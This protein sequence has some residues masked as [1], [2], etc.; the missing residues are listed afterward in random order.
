VESRLL[1]GR[2][3]GSGRQPG[4]LREPSFHVRCRRDDCTSIHDEASS[5]FCRSD[6]RMNCSKSNVYKEEGVRRN[7]RPSY[8]ELSSIIKPTGFSD[9][10]QVHCK[11]NEGTTSTICF[12]SGRTEFTNLLPIHCSRTYGHFHPPGQSP[13]SHPGI[14][15]VR[16][17]HPL[18]I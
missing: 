18:R 12:R 5:Y 14:T 2:E 6:T 1:I 3:R 13:S 11:L 16:H 7:E 17:P 15:I 4:K 8:Q 10:V 9:E